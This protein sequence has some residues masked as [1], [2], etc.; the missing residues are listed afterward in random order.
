MPLHTACCVGIRNFIGT[1]NGKSYVCCGCWY[2]YC[3]INPLLAAVAV[4]ML[5]LASLYNLYDREGDRASEKKCQWKAS[6]SNAYATLYAENVIWC[7]LNELYR[8]PMIFALVTLAIYPLRFHTECCMF[9]SCALM[10]RAKL[11][12]RG[13][14]GGFRYGVGR[15]S[16]RSNETHVTRETL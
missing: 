7:H 11:I 3:Y 16:M 4:A 13:E 12:D 1:E 6:P 14:G 15:R 2:S 5:R 8:L 10:T 9:H